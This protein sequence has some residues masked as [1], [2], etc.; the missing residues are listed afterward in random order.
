MPQAPQTSSFS[1][2]NRTQHK[3]LVAS[4]GLFVIAVESALL[5]RRYLLASRPSTWMA[6]LAPRSPILLASQAVFKASYTLLL[7]P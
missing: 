2:V 6:A 3:V 7:A 4:P 5:V 1:H